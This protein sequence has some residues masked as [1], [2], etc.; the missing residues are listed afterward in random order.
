MVFSLALR[1]TARNKINNLIIIILVAVICFLF[2][3]GNSIIEK[4]YIG[5]RQAF[6]E[7]LTGD[8]VIQKKGDITMNLFGANA[9]VI[10]PFFVVPVLP[11]FDAIMK[12]VSS[13]R[14]ISGITSQVS[15]NSF[16][17]LLGV[18]DS[19]L[20][21]G[22][23]AQT[24][25]SMFPGIVLEEGRFLHNGEYGAMITTG[26]AK[27]I[28]ELG[29]SYP[30]IGESVLLTSG[31]T[32]GFKIMDIPLVGIFSYQNPGLFMNDIIITDPQTVR[33]LNSIQ[34]AASQDVELN[35][36]AM[37]LLSSDIDDIFNIESFSNGHTSEEFSVDVLQSWLAETTQD[38]YADTTGGDWHFIIINLEKN[39]NPKSF[40][41]SMN[42]KL[43]SYDVVAVD[44]RTSAGVSTILLLLIQVLFNAGMF[45]VCVAG[46]I[47]VINIL[48]ISVFRRTREIGTL[49]AIGASDLYVSSLILCENLILSVIA[50][51][52]GI[53]AGYL[54]FNWINSL[55]FKIPNELIASLLGGDILNLVFIP[56]VA[57]FSFL[58]AVALGVIVSIYPIFFTLKIEPVEAVRQ[59]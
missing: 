58:L 48:L 57:F 27:R 13:E 30:Q 35:D 45:L 41:K 1:N 42:K 51:V 5:L 16:L 23:D 59:G 19:A 29:G 53:A 25:F 54:F 14:G 31:G 20:L 50:G 46:V 24:Y 56:K 33:V 52:A 10:D 36:D 26:R 44:W 11:A 3:I 28:E 17:D 12:I 8:V 47:S 18:R 49:R 2:F 9:P 43:E 22:I 55:S 39:V 32:L 6:I 7:S 34:V 4:S 37:L 40:I 21:C 38:I 15:G